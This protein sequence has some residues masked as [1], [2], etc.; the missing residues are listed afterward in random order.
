MKLLKWLVAVGAL[1]AFILACWYYRPWSDYSPSEMADLSDPSKYVEN[2][3][4]MG[5]KIPYRTVSRGDDTSQFDELPGPLEFTYNYDGELKTL[6]Q[7]HEE[8]TTTSLIVVKDGAILHERY[9]QGSN[10]ESLFTSWSVAKSFVATVIAIALQEG[11]I[12]SLDDPA[13]KYATQFSDTDFGASS[14]RSLLAMSTGVEFNEDYFSEDSDIRPFFFD[15]FVLGKNPDELLAP[16][17]RTRSEFTDFHYISSNS[18][19]L[20]AVLRAVYKKPLAE[21]MA[22]KIWQPLGMEADGTWL[23]HRKGDDGLALGY[24]CLNARSRDYARFGQFYLDAYLNQTSSKI[25][26]PESW[27]RALAKPA[28]P[29]HRPGGKLYS[30]RG[31][32]NHFWLPPANP[33]V[34]FAAGV[35]GQYIWIDPARNLVIVRTSADPEFI[36]RFAESALVFE[37]IASQFDALR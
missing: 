19:V 34:F 28:S 2:F 13:Q 22:E 27:A 20:S 32:S 25:E 33:G 30:G 37:A 3:R 35:Y 15:S 29:V 4:S 5:D 14:I 17:K 16:F 11:L 36:P 21:I 12:Q 18:H 23:Q 6:E 31:Y 24:C 10:R 7:F 9:F 8:S 26:L 1:A